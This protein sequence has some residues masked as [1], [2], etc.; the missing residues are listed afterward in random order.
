VS[1]LLN[2]PFEHYGNTIKKKRY[3]TKMGKVTQVIG[4]IIQVEGLEVF[5][6]EL[7][8]ILIKLSDKVIPAE[9]VGF[10]GHTVLLMP[11]AELDGIGPGC[12]VRPTGRALKVKISD[13]LLGRTLD[14]LGNPM[15]VDISFE[16]KLY[17]INRTPPNPFERRKIENTMGTGIKAIDGILTCGEGQRIGIFAGSGVGKSTLLGMMAKYSDADVNVIALVGERGR[18]VLEFIE[19]DLGPEGYKKSVVVCATSDQPPLVRLKGAFVATT[20]AEYFRD[21]GKKVVLMMD[22]VTRFAMAQREIG[23]ATGEPPTT[24]GYTP[25]VFAMLPKLLERSGMSNKGSITAFYTVLVEGDDMNEPIA[26]A[27]RGI[28]DGHI[29]LSRKIAAKNHFPAIDIQSSVSRIMKEIV[30]EEHYEIAGK[31]KENLAVYSDSEDLINIGAYIKGS[32]PIIDKAIDLN[33][34]INEFLKQGVN[35]RY[36]Y[37]ETLKALKN[38]MI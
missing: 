32:N 24:R 15:D 38:L 9:V 10:R 13:E 37:E 7:C 21:Q 19:K 34:P 2:I 26:D 30:T 36:S 1:Y 8:E 23:L 12:L 27:V 35:E 6:G 28:L 33:R 14:G 31:L 11:L 17:D 3:Y 20:I 25:S 18:E 5:M 22:S 4:L 16:G 29:I